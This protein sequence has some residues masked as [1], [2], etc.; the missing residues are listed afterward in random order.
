MKFKNE[1]YL[2]SVSTGPTFPVLPL[3]H[4]SGEDNS[5]LNLILT[6]RTNEKQGNGERETTKFDRS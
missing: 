3:R 4:G 5:S 2:A 1:K 6:N